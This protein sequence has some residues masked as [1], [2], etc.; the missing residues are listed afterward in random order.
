MIDEAETRSTSFS[1]S[2][3]FSRT[4]SRRPQC[5]G[6]VA[7]AA[8]GAAAPAVPGAAASDCF[9]S[10]VG[11]LPERGGT[12][13]GSEESMIAADARQD[14][15]KRNALEA[16][17][18]RDSKG[19]KDEDQMSI[20]IKAAVPHYNSIRRASII[21]A[22]TVGAGKKALDQAV[23]EVVDQVGLDPDGVQTVAQRKQ[24]KASKTLAREQILSAIEHVE[25]LEKFR[26]AGTGEP[27]RAMAVRENAGQRRVQF[28][29]AVAKNAKSP[30]ELLA[31]SVLEEAASTLS[32]NAQR[33]GSSFAV[34]SGSL[35]TLMAGPAT[36]GCLLP[37]QSVEVLPRAPNGVPLAHLT[38]ADKLRMKEERDK[39]RAWHAAMRDDNVSEQGDD[40]PLGPDLV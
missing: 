8:T 20:L 11:T 22:K 7:A 34:R 16:R 25:Q 12:V 19:S 4:R 29:D 10:S 27:G 2:S 28:D 33:R 21:A 17:L 9:G 13:Y 37:R 24:L 5:R 18:Q 1:P 3:P 32:C 31:V 40:M 36:P 38:A 30:E 23:D 35:K 15:L 14:V 6:A 26:T 39:G